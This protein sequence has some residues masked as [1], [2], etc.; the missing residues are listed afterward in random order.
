MLTPLLLRERTVPMQP[1]ISVTQGR[2]FQV[3]GAAAGILGRQK[4]KGVEDPA[5]QKSL[6][7]GAP[8]GRKE[9]NVNETEKKNGG[10]RYQRG[11]AYRGGGGRRDARQSS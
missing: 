11:D 8:P 3:G 1:C 10:K 9:K 4:L 5:A 7:V 2:S 6:G